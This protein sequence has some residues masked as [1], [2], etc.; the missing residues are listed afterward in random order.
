MLST[1]CPELNPAERVFKELRKVLA[2]RVFLNKEEVE[3][4]L[5]FWI[6]KYQADPDAIIK[7]TKF[8]FLEYTT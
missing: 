6:Q 8:S 4:C 2:N 7:L 3:K 5:T 1:A